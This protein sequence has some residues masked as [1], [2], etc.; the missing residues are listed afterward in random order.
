MGFYLGVGCTMTFVFSC[1]LCTFTTLF[2]HFG[3]RLLHLRTYL[4]QEGELMRT[5]SSAVS[6]K[7]S[8]KVEPSLILFGLAELGFKF[9][10]ARVIVGMPVFPTVERVFNSP[11]AVSK[12]VVAALGS[13]R[14]FRG[15][16][17]RFGGSYRSQF[18]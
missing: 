6:A 3:K 9:G 14:R 11:F 7:L 5:S 12:F 2:G 10:F 1:Y 15:W 17:C 18:D 16:P 4:T 13:G 8:R